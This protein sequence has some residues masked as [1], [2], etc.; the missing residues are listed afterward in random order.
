MTDALPSSRFQQAID[1]IEALSLEE[2]QHLL[3][4]L[5]KRLQ[6]QCRSQ[7]FQEVEDIHQEI[8]QGN[9]RYGSVKDFLAQLDAF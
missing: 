9:I 3:D 4:L 5:S 1:V 6:Q 2:Q 7:I 8:A